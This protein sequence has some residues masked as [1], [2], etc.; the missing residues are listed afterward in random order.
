MRVIVCN[1]CYGNNPYIRTAEMALKLSDKLGGKV[2]VVIPHIYG[3]QQKRILTEEFGHDAR[4]ILDEEFG[5]ILRSVFFEGDSYKQF[6]QQW[7][8]TVD[9]ASNKAMT[10]LKKTYDI[11]CEISRSPLLDLGITP[12]FYNSWSRISDV[13]ERA[14]GEPAIALDHELLTTASKKMR[15]LESHYSAHFISVPGTFEPN[16]NDIAIPLSTS[17]L[18][19][20][21]QV[22]ERGV[23][24]TVSGIPHVESLQT[25]ADA[26]NVKIYSSDS[27]KIRGSQHALPGILKHS[28]IVAHIARAGWGAIGKSIATG[29]PLIVQPYQK[30]E[31]PEIYFNIQRIEELGLG[32]QFSGQNSDELLKILE[33]LRP[34]IQEYKE[35][36]LRRFGTL[37][38]ASIAV[39]SMLQYLKS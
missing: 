7:L 19:S 29:V 30:N 12:A 2:F 9:D 25:I 3:E 38:G 34:R 18:I 31:D 6:L 14:I 36:L 11:V 15:A 21:D 35:S 17:T 5:S 32:V 39:E 22:V 27:S 1:P 37:D 26:L 23:Y 13:L 24:V 4:V 33:G 16:K 28:Q 10:H 20:D 8:N